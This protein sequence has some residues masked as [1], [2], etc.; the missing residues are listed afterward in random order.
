MDS[1][2]IL[3][4]PIFLIVCQTTAE[5]VWY[6]KKRVARETRLFFSRALLP[7][8]CL[9]YIGTLSARVSRVEGSCLGLIGIE[10]GGGEG[11]LDLDELIDNLE[12]NAFGVG[13]GP[14]A[15]EQ[16]L[17]AVVIPIAMR[18]ILGEL[19]A[20]AVQLL[21]TIIRTARHSSTTDRRQL[22]SIL[23]RNMGYTIFSER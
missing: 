3:S 14:G 11:L 17:G 2:A 5:R 20:T 6:R 21:R 12:I 16:C 10:S 18:Q 4:T 15:I 8:A 22:L 23:G 7:S 9:V 19:P 13:D 1:S